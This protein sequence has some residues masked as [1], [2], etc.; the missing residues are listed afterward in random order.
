MD[1]DIARKDELES[2]L[3]PRPGLPLWYPATS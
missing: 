2:V 1:D 3:K